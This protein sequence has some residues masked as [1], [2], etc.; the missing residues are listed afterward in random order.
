MRHAAPILGMLCALAAPA[1]FAGTVVTLEVRGDPGHELV[2]LALEGHDLRVDRGPVE[3]APTTSL[4]FRG[5]S[6]EMLFLDHGK[7]E[8]L[9]YDAHT[10]HRIAEAMASGAASGDAEGGTGAPRTTLTERDG[11]GVTRGWAWREVELRSAGRPVATARAAAAVEL[12]LEPAD[13]AVVGD[14]LD[15]VEPIS[16]P[17]GDSFGLRFPVDRSLAALAAAGRFPILLRSRAKDGSEATSSL[18][19]IESVSLPPERFEDPGYP[20]PSFEMHGH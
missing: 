10:I 2:T 5:A 1:L 19:S 15:F 7:P 16:G 13:L 3:G 4:I 20:R 17:F 14:L 11:S 8:T 9:P 18:V 12:G 6:R